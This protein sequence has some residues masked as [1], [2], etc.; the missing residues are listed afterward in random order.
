MPDNPQR[1]SPSVAGHPSRRLALRCDLTPTSRPAQSTAPASA[2]LGGHR[3]VPT[4]DRR[5]GTATV[6]AIR[7]RL[8]VCDGDGGEVQAV[9]GRRNDGHHHPT[10][11]LSWQ[12]IPTTNSSP[13]DQSSSEVACHAVR[14]AERHLRLLANP[15]DLP[16]SFVPSEFP[17]LDPVRLLTE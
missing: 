3:F 10:I 12:A 17:R 9:S 4:V 1:A 15:A 11:A 16:S 8:V 6:R 14:L 5:G 13:S 2:D 7:D